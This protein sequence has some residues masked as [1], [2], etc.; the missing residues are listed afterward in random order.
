M[1][2]RNLDA[3][4]SNPVIIGAVAV[5]IIVGGIFLLS[6]SEKKGDGDSMKDKESSM[7][8][9]EKDG[10]VMDGD[11]MV[12]K[13]GDSSFT[14]K[15]QNNSGQ[16][17]TVSFEAIDR[18]TKV[19][20]DVASYDSTPQ[21]AHIHSGSCSELGGIFYKLNNVVDGKSETDIDIFLPL[22]AKNAPLAVNVHKS[23][24]ELKTSVSCANIT[25]EDK[26]AM[27]KEDKMMEES[28][29]EDKGDKMMEDSGAMMKK[30][31][32]MM[33]EGHDGAMM[34]DDKMMKEDKMMEDDKMMKEDGAMMEE[35]YS[36]Q[37]LAGTKAKLLDFNKADY[38]KAVASGKLVTLFFYA[39]WCP[40]CQAEFPEAQA[41]FNE[42]NTDQV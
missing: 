11:S 5:I 38:D 12:M 7:M 30:E 21:P 37:V 6:S 29:M 15:E 25:E 19:I 28:M 16:A 8:E 20:L 39:T 40:S 42:L 9:K 18:K 17:G 4:F 2:K 10:A 36:G 22:L 34:E 26:D 24:D 31:E 33:E 27:M 23:A 3:G 13:E 41:A 14:M 35:K 32:S 1:Q